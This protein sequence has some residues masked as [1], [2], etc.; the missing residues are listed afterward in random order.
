MDSCEVISDGASALRRAQ[1]AALR[2]AHIVRQA[3]I[4]VR[5]A[6]V[7]VRM[8][9]IDFARWLLTRAR[10]ICVVDVTVIETTAT[11]NT[12]IRTGS[13][14]SIVTMPPWLA[15]RYLL[16]SVHAARARASTRRC[17]LERR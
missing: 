3:D 7:F 16:P 15:S 11:A 8:S 9:D 4:G 6:D 1:A 5:N 10:R 12:T 2:D 13:A 17:R 14:A